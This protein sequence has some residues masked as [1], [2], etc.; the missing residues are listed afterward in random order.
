MKQRSSDRGR[1]GRGERVGRRI[2]DGPGAAPARPPICASVCVRVVHLSP[3][4]FRMCASSLST[5]FTSC[6]FVVPGQTTAAAARRRRD[7]QTAAEG[8]ADGAATDS[9]H[10]PARCTQRFDDQHWPS[11]T[12]H[13]SG[14][15][16]AARQRRVS[17]FLTVSDVADEHG[18]S[19]RRG[20]G[21]CAVGQPLGL[22]EGRGE[23]G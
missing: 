22:C 4:C 19:T 10:K 9:E 14:D 17:F 3:N 15:R 20:H 8:R 6:S 13:A 23:K 16:L 18:E 1:T 12:M 5:R 2:S 7:G 21:C 11:T